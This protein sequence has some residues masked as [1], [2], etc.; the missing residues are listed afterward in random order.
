M[1][2]HSVRLHPL[3]PRDRAPYTSAEPGTDLPARIGNTPLV[4]LRSLEPHEGVSVYAKAEWAN[5]GGSVKD[6][7]A[8]SM[9][10]DGERTG[11]LTPG[12]TLLDA[13]SGNT[14]IAYA[15][16]G[17][18]LGY[19][20]EL[21][22]PA[23]ISRSRVRI[24]RA[25]GAVLHLTDAQEGMDGAI[26][27]A[28]HRA[29]DEGDRVF[30]PDQYNNP[31]NWLAHYHGTAEEIL[32]QTHGRVTH[33]VAGLGTT[34][35]FTGTGRRLKEF[36]PGIRLI[37]MQPD[38]PLHAMEGLKHLETTAH[39]PGIYDAELADGD[40]AISTER[41]RATALELARDEGLLVGPSAAAA[42]AAVRQVAGGLGTGVVVTV[43]PDS[44]EKYLD[45]PFWE[46]P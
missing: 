1:A 41:A 16:L 7:A 35:T 22:L 42:A 14:G 31:A 38:S 11:R 33:F 32:R 9:I 12:K 26:E 10:R 21:Y 2:S 37:G 30:Y 28:R 3:H 36:N 44:A 25:L 8:L 29:A 45:E 34:G 40:T 13:S 23:N 39:V 24:L 27:A 18:A 19:P 17:A 4:R 15:M 46:V 20:V 5:P 6:R 43:F